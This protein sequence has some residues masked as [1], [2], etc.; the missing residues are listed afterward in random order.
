VRWHYNV[1]ID[2]PELM[3]FIRDE[4]PDVEWHYRIGKRGKYAGEKQPFFRRVRQKLLVPTRWRRWCCAEFK[5]NPGP[6]G[7]TRLLGVRCEESSARNARYTADVMPARGGRREVYPIRS[8]NTYHV[9]KFIEDNRVPYE[10]EDAEDMESRLD[11]EAKRDADAEDED[12]RLHREWVRD[13]R[14]DWKREDY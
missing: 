9:W 1:I 14:A 7:C 4:H 6:R 3:R 13:Q 10:D 11:R 2:P 5:H 8:W 12:E